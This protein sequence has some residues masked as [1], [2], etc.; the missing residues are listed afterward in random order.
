MNAAKYVLAGGLAVVGPHKPAVVN[1]GESISYGDL[2]VRVSRF[3]AALREVGMKPGDRVALFMLDHAD[4]VSIY[5]AVMAAGGVA[6]AHER[7][8]SANPCDYPAVRRHR[9][10]RL[11][12]RHNRR[13]GA[14]C[15]IVSS[16]APSVVVGAKIRDGVRALCPQAGR[17]G[18]LG[19]DVRHYRTA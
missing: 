13:H 18:V 2:A 19:D 17:S 16:P 1:G 10:K 7:R 8:S 9:R 6:I 5:L 3:A 15:K 11:R 12:T 4:L 14:E